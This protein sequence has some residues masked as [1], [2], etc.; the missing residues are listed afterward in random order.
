MESGRERYREAGKL[1][2]VR[3]MKEKIGQVEMWKEIVCLINVILM[4]DYCFNNKTV[5]IYHQTIRTAENYTRRTTT[6]KSSFT[7]NVNTRN[8]PLYNLNLISHLVHINN[9]PLRAEVNFVRSI[10]LSLHFLLPLPL[11]Y[12]YHMATCKNIVSSFLR[13]NFKVEWA[14]LACSVS[15]FAD[16]PACRPT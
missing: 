13:V 15:C 4:C 9:P 6:P 16:S 11:T 10:P 3:V 14:R 7:S 1:D 8:P 2:G 5:H 12:T